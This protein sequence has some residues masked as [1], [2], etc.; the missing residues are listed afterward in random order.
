MSSPLGEHSWHVSC[1]PLDRSVNV[2]VLHNPSFVCPLNPDLLDLI[3]RALVTGVVVELDGAQ[4]FVCG[5]ELPIFE[6]AAG[7][8]IGRV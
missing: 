1:A 5:H 7:I 4:A 6:H 2:G 3:E 8:Y